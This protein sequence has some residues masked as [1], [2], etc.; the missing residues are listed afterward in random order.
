MSNKF[1]SNRF[2][3]I[4]II[5]LAFVISLSLDYNQ[6]VIEAGLILA[7]QI[8]FPSPLSPFYLYIKNSWTLLNQF[9][10]GLFI[11]NFS[12]NFI[13][14]LF[15]FIS[16]LMFG[17]GIYLT[18]KAICQNYLLSLFITIYALML[19]KNFGDTDYP[20]L[21]YSQ[22]T[23]GMISLSLS[24]L[25][26]GLIFNGNLRL[27]SFLSII[28]FAIH[29]LIGIWVLGINF[30]VFLINLNKIELNQL[31]ASI[32]LGFLLIILSFILFYSNADL[33]YSYQINDYQ[34]Y[35][36][37]WDG[38]RSQ[39]EIFHYEYII[40][41]FLLIA[42]LISILKFNPTKYVKMGCQ[43]I[44]LSILISL[45]IY[46]LFKNFYNLTPAFLT[47]TSI[48]SRFLIQHSIVGWPILISGAL[49]ILKRLNIFYEKKYSLIIVSVLTIHLLMQHN[50]IMAKF[51]VPFS[52]FKNSTEQKSV[53]PTVFDNNN[54]YVLTNNSL[55]RLVLH[56]LKKPILVDIGQLDF[57]PYHKYLAD[58]V[59]EIIQ[60]VYKV[61]FKKPP[62]LNAPYLDDKTIHNNFSKI[63]LDEWKQISEKFNIKFIV[64]PEEVKMMLTPYLNFNNLNV[65]FLD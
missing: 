48:P 20:T 14:F 29:P 6:R 54:G 64:L 11:L 61:D 25:I 8:E 7:N 47:E 4:F 3:F 59:K 65:Y 63:S 45:P 50:S 21:F 58:E 60:D 55:S 35:I 52:S 56:D 43:I 5:S 53:V 40:K 15:I 39:N 37:F 23:Y 10:A 1:F 34:D 26:F 36:N 16:T 42:V 22:E 27:A 31:I 28:L 17:L 12:Q 33:Q 62:I 46:L 24:T 13:S 49:L 38:H 41:T 18:S 51:N 19:G 32:F 2:N 44:L 9:A 57:L 30:L